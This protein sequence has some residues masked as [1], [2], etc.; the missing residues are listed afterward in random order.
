MHVICLYTLYQCRA[1]SYI[2]T[3]CTHTCTRRHLSCGWLPT[4][5]GGRTYRSIARDQCSLPKMPLL[6][7]KRYHQLPP[8]TKIY[9]GHSD[10]NITNQPTRICLMGDGA[11]FTSPNWSS[12]QGEDTQACPHVTP[13][14]SWFMEVLTI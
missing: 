14:N 6:L 4:H 12:P 2:Q 3:T 5:T 8:A 13:W 9:R 10:W 11:F 1:Y 7:E